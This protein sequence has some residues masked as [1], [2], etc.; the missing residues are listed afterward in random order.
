MF[1]DRAGHLDS[2][3]SFLKRYVEPINY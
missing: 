3:P 1:A 2:I